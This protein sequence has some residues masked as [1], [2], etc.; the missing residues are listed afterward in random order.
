MGFLDLSL[1]EVA[2]SVCASQLENDEKTSPKQE[3]HLGWVLK[4]HFRFA[5]GTFF[6][7]KP[8]K[9]SIQSNL[10]TQQTCINFQDQKIMDI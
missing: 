1:P 2:F 8:K 3:S 10:I 6:R 7:R 5:V 4:T 9:L